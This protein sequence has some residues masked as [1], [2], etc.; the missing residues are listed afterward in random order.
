MK[1]AFS[2]SISAAVGWEIEKVCWDEKKGGGEKGISVV[3]DRKKVNDNKFI[4]SFER[5]I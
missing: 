4:F 2:A 3:L 5:S 1:A